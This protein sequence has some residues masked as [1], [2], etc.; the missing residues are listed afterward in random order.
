MLSELVGLQVGLRGDVALAMLT[1]FPCRSDRCC[2]FPRAHSDQL[3]YRVDG[4]T[5]ASNSYQR[6][7]RAKFVAQAM[8]P[9]VVPSWWGECLS[10]PY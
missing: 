7:E 3:G 1:G 9:I 10:L 4:N 2:V 6:S 8:P 5:G